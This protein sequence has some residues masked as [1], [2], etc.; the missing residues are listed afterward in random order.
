MTVIFF[1]RNYWSNAEP[2]FI[3]NLVEKRNSLEDIEKK[4]GVWFM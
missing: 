1:D 3:E 4:V 2:R